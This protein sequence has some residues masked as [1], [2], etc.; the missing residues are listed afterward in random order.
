M[1]GTEHRVADRA[2]WAKV[3]SCVKRARSQANR[4]AAEIGPISGSSRRV[5][6]SERRRSAW[7]Y[8]VRAPLLPARGRPTGRPRPG[9]AR[10]AERQG[11]SAVVVA[12]EH[13]RE[14]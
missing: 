6:P 12:D 7:C 3:G 10:N 4:L 8:V 13:T 1:H 14:L 11:C 9:N 2:Q 5:L